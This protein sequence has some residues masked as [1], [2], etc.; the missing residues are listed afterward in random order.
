MLTLYYNDQILDQLFDVQINDNT[1]II[2][3]FAPWDIYDVDGHV[4]M[5]FGMG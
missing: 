4:V 2:G 5:D 3:T 1:L